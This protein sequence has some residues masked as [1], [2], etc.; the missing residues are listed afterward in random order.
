MV[1][2]KK[3]P[4]GP[5]KVNSAFSGSINDNFIT[6]A[7]GSIEPQIQNAIIGAFK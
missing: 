6:R 5:F 3:A 1:S 2:L 4:I 7:L